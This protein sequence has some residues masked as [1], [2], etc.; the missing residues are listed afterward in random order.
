MLRYLKRSDSAA[1]F[2]RPAKLSPALHRLLMERGIDSAE[3]AER[4]LNPDIRNLYDPFLLSDMDRAVDMIR[5]AIAEGMPICVWGDYDVDGVSASAIMLKYLKDQG[6]R[7]EVYL[8]SRH[9]EGYGLNENGIREIAGWAKL[10]VTVDCGVTSVEL[11]ELAKSLGLQVVITD[12][13]RPGDN[14]PDCPV[15]NPL[16]KDYPFPFLCGAGVAWKLIWALSGELPIH[17]I[18]IAALATVADI[19]SLT[20]ENRVIVA[21]G[22]QSINQ[23]PRTGLQ[24]LIESAGLKGKN[25]TSTSIAF[26]LAPRLNAGGRLDTAMAPFQLL[27][28]EDAAEAKRLSEALEEENTK[29]REIEQQIMG[30]AEAQLRDFDFIH[31]RAIIL[32]GAGWN[33][34]VIGLAASRLVE[35]YHYPVI[36]L[37]D[38][39]EKLTGSCR[40][41]EG[42]DI[43]AALT[44]CR[45]H[46]VKY[47]G[48]KQAAGLTLKP[49]ALQPFI[50]GMDEWLRQNAPPEI[51]IPVEKYD[52]ELDFEAVTPGL[53]ASL[54]ALQPTGM[55]NPAPVFRAVADVLEARAVGST[56]AH[57]KLTLSQQGQRIGGIAF[58][59]GD[60]AD[61]LSGGNT[62]DVLFVPKLNEY[63][64]RVTAQLEV[65]AIKDVHQI[66]PKVHKET[67]LLCDF[68]TE[69]LYNNRISFDDNGEVLSDSSKAPSPIDF[70]A[71]AERFGQSPQGAI[72]ITS[73]YAEAARLMKTLPEACAPDLYTSEWP[74]DPRAFNAICVCPAKGTMPRGYT[75]VTLCGVP[76]GVLPQGT[77]YYRLE[78]S[79]D[80]FNQL[81]ELQT[82]R[83]VYRGL[84]D[85][86]R[87]PMRFFNLKQ[88]NQLV[89]DSVGTDPIGTLAS[90]IAI[91]AMGLFEYNFSVAPARILRLPAK[92]AE[93]EECPLWRTLQRWRQGNLD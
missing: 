39:G 5:G 4:F 1:H 21:C 31:H 80:W 18:D 84:M 49:E 2:E 45:E 53:I 46:L 67:A 64:G 10:L 79:S 11:V 66:E 41:I 63:M 58:R 25:I 77:P 85:L 33:P 34:G 3:T 52:T 57:L 26:Q 68:L 48:H 81:P 65:K 22:L 62:L 60:R 54:E 42:V 86:S 59:A 15:V 28:T 87:R 38:Q 78:A 19:V 44:G 73:E 92:K 89:A 36:M 8:P 72:L 51:Y 6:A 83:Q 35:Q 32:S 50:D 74:E 23:N 47:G 56:G 43:H 7:A 37:S 40:S 9:T 14:L 13:H 88:L 17:L 71:L 55:G 16:L 75:H 27:M 70:D 90:I 29:R 69:I 91:E 24:A 93:P 20:D 61:R 76:R 12:H 82:M 30:E